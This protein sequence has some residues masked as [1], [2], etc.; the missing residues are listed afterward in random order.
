MDLEQ[1]FIIKYTD[2]SSLKC[3]S[4][5]LVV[6]PEVNKEPSFMFCHQIVYSKIFLICRN[7]FFISELLLRDWG[8]VVAV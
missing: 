4:F 3:M 5:I 7:Y 1:Y 8:A 6:T 2:V